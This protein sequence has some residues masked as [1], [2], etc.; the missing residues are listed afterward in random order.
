VLASSSNVQHGACAPQWT[1][2]ELHPPNPLQDILA[3]KC[4]SIVTLSWLPN[5]LHHCLHSVCRRVAAEL[6]SP[7]KTDHVLS[8]PDMRSDLCSAGSMAG[9]AKSGASSKFTPP[10]VR[11]KPACSGAAGL[12][13]A[14]MAAGQSP[15]AGQNDSCCRMAMESC[16]PQQE[17]SDLGK[18]TTQLTYAPASPDLIAT[19][20]GRAPRKPGSFAVDGNSEAAHGEATEYDAASEQPASGSLGHIRPAKIADGGQP[21]RGGSIDVHLRTLLKLAKPSALLERRQSAGTSEH[22]GQ[23]ALDRAPDKHAGGSGPGVLPGWPTAAALHPAV[24][25]LQDMPSQQGEGSTDVL[26]EANIVSGL[27]PSLAMECIHPQATGAFVDVSDEAQQ[28]PWPDH[29][30]SKL[31]GKKHTEGKEADLEDPVVPDNVTAS[32]KADDKLAASA[33]HDQTLG[34]PVKLDL[35][36]DNTAEVMVKSKPNI[37]VPFLPELILVASSRN[38][39]RSIRFGVSMVYSANKHRVLSRCCTLAIVLHIGCLGIARSATLLPPPHHELSSMCRQHGDQVQLED[40]CCSVRC[41]C[42]SVVEKQPKAELH[43]RAAARVN[44]HSHVTAC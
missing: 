36:A 10:A 9:P 20:G 13:I 26:A 22:S 16:A 35:G 25:E 44:A 27:N 6:S 29:P 28:L 5:C 37:Q 17:K 4:A 32:S 41:V 1:L 11:H 43:A 3:S 31:S 14:H 33:L 38:I 7:V 42:S 12:A 2:R 24:P 40:S 34:E 30:A 8:Y 18:V 39:S 19:N 15:Q 21:F 23:A